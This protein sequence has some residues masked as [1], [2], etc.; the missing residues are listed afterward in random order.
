MGKNISL[1]GK[2]KR[3][4]S[5][6]AACLAEEGYECSIVD[7]LLDDDLNLADLI[8]YDG[9]ILTEDSLA[10]LPVILRE[11][12]SIFFISSCSKNMAAAYRNAG[13]DLVFSKPISRTELISIV[14]ALIG[15][16]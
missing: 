7:N 16:A 13:I 1:F 8:I 3:N 9:E 12:K 4:L 5:L 10:K 6:M 2:N 11:K 15:D 14:A